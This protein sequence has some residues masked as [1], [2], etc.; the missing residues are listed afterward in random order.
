M[1][2]VRLKFI[3]HHM[4]FNV[5]LKKLLQQSIQVEPDFR[6]TDQFVVIELHYVFGIDALETSRP[7]NLQVTTNDEINNMFD[8]IS[9]DKGI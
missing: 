7:I 8:G 2:A 5:I 4:D 1:D 3:S 6:F 9:Y